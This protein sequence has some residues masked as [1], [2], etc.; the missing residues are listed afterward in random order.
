MKR[1]TN[2]YPGDSHAISR[3]KRSPS[4]QHFSVSKELETTENCW[5]RAAESRR[6]TDN[7]NLWILFHSVFERRSP[8]LRGSE[9]CELR[10]RTACPLLGA[11]RAAVDSAG[12]SGVFL[13]CTVDALNGC[14]RSSDS[15][16]SVENDGALVE[17]NRD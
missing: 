5:M 7:N 14:H 9:P 17:L 13:L 16:P 3:D 1:L 11:N 10:F 15:T 6:K 4:S 12:R 8:T 2:G